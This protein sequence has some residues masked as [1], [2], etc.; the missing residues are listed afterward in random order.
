MARAER[1]RRV[2]TRIWC[3]DRG[4]PAAPGGPAAFEGLDLRAQ[5]G[6]QDNARGGFPLGLWWFLRAG[7]RFDAQGP[8]QLGAMAAGLTPAAAS[9][10][11]RR[12][13]GPG[14]PSMSSISH[15]RQ[16]RVACGGRRVSASTRSSLTSARRP[17]FFPRRRC[18]VRWV[19][20]RATG[21][22]FRSLV[23]TRIR[24]R[25]ASGTASVSLPSG[26]RCSCRSSTVRGKFQV[27]PGVVSAGPPSQCYWCDTSRRSLVSK[28]SALSWCSTGGP[29]PRTPGRSCNGGRT[30]EF[31]TS[32]FAFDFNNWCGAHGRILRPAT[33]GVSREKHVPIFHAALVGETGWQPGHAGECA[34]SR[35]GV[36]V[37][38]RRAGGRTRGPG[39]PGR[40][41]RQ[42]W[43]CRC[44]CRPPSRA[45]YSSSTTSVMCLRGAF[46]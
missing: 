21:S 22:S 10:S 18:T 1:M 9:S 16:R 46:G 7:G 29:T 30:A 12:P 32:Y 2:A 44:G 31:S 4:H 11:A 25:R 35:P 28:Y 38:S 6:E 41:V 8:C 19:V 24:S 17:S 33:P 27:P 45:S 15:S 20:S 14:T 13:G 34:G 40:C 36:R 3:T 26:S 5:V 37:S 42:A 43:E 39:G 23:C